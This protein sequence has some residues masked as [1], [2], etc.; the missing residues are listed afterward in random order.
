MSD[1]PHAHRRPQRQASLAWRVIR[2]IL[3]VLGAL[4]ILFM[5]LG[6]TLGSSKPAARPGPLP[7]V[8]VTVARPVPGPTVTVTPSRPPVTV[9]AN[10]T[11]ITINVPPD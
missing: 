5:V 6:I 2:A 7:A 3:A 4:F 8:T 10:P 11:V 9:S 1:G